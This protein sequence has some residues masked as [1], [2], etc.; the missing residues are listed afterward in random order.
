MF[1]FSYIYEFLLGSKTNKKSCKIIIWKLIVLLE[2]IRD[3]WKNIVPQRNFPSSRASP[4]KTFGS[5]CK[6]RNMGTKNTCFAFVVPLLVS[7]P[8]RFFPTTPSTFGCCLSLQLQS[9]A[10]AAF[11]LVPIKNDVPTSTIITKLH[12][13][14]VCTHITHT[15]F[16]K[17]GACVV[18]ILKNIF[19]SKCKIPL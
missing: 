14:Y 1:L 18:L 7:I 17:M 9:M 11:S 3:F 10:M 2:L 13:L 15:R 4:P 12:S 6:S 5:N 19:K 16:K 8:L